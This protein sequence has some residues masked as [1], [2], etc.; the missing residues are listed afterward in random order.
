MPAAIGPRTVALVLAALLATPAAAQVGADASGPA[1]HPL[2]PHYDGAELL[3]REAEEFTDYA[4]RTGKARAAGTRTVEG[5]LTRLTYQAPRDRAVLEV[6]RNYEAALRQAGYEIVFSCARADC[7][8][9]RK[10]IASGPRYML[11]W[12]GDEH[13]YLSARRSAAGGEVSVALFVTRN[14][15]G[16]PARGRA[17]IQLDVVESRPMDERMTL[18]E[19]DA[20]GAELDRSGRATLYGIEFDFA[21]DTLRPESDAQLAQIARLLERDRTLSVRVVGHTDAQGAAAYN[22]DLSRRRAQRIVDALAGEHG[23]ARDRM[24]AEGVGASQP[25]ADNTT[26]DGRARNRR[27]EIIRR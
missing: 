25:V 18:V 17:M 12:A 21:R 23:I 13:R 9:I 11:L 1:Q 7:G 3:R 5:R 16:G 27:V 8:D 6:F 19:A 15:S 10:D 14:E 2:V 26:E 24:Q 22:L 20:L 4:L